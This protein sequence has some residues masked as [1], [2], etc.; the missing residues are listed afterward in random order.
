M[1]PDLS[2]NVCIISEICFISY[3]LQCNTYRENGLDL[4]LIILFSKAIGYLCICLFFN[5]SET[6]QPNELK[7]WE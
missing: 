2:I 6:V 4:K 5:S 7:F 1:P 3:I